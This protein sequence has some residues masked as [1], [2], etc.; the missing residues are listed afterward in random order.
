[1]RPTFM[2]D[3]DVLKLSLVLA[4]AASAYGQAVPT[5]GVLDFYGIHKTSESKIR[6]VLGAKVGDP[7]PPSKGDVEERLDEIS[8]VV[9]S[10]LEAVC[11]NAG[12]TILY[13]G[14]EERSA[15]HFELRDPPDGEITLP[16]EVASTY[17]R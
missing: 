7:L 16:G 10:H 2:S 9:E 1:M 14:I 6:Q 15:P 3:R 13:V 11:C 5:I 4:M 12:K 8:G 17:R